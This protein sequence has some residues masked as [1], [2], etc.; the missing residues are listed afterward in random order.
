MTEGILLTAAEPGT[1][2]L[3]TEQFITLVMVLGI[4]G[5]ILIF[6]AKHQ[7]GNFDS[8][9]KNLNSVIPALKS[10]LEEKIQD[11]NDGLEEQ[12]RRQIQE[13][14][15]RVNERMERLEEKGSHEISSI[16]KEISEI[17]SDCAITYVQRDDFFRAMNG[18]EEN[19]RETGRKVDKVLMIIGEKKN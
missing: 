3:G 18:V 17:K 19:I 15:D 11:S 5:T 7:F 6:L 2:Y 14:N 8:G 16:K 13:N 9:I 10:S 1:I 4:C 12:L